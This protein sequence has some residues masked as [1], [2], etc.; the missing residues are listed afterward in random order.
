MSTNAS[1]ATLTPTEVSSRLQQLQGWSV[2]DGKKLAKAFRFKNFVQA[3]DF[4]NR[5]T[6]VAEEEGHHPDLYVTWGEV[7]VYL[8]SHSAGGLT[9]NDFAM[10]A[11]I[12]KL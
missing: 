8:T 6:K 11:K 10:A 5:I 12:D 1:P 4:V 2:E 7:T 3:V 9:Q